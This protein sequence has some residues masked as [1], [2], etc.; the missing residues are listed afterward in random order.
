MAPYI[1]INQS[2]SN[3]IEKFEYDYIF[4]L[5]MIILQIIFTAVSSALIAYLYKDIMDER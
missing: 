3:F 4:I 1:L 5:M 2:I